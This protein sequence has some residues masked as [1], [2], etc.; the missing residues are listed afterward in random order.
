M[1]L[2]PQPAHLAASLLLALTLSSAANAEAN[3]CGINGDCAD[4]TI[5]NISSA[6]VTAVKIEQHTTDGACKYADN[7]YSQNLSGWSEESFEVAL[8][9]NCK[10]KIKFK[11]TSGC[12]GDKTTH[13]TPENFAAGKE[14]VQLEGACGSLK[15]YKL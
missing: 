15:T 7:N 11:T 2:K 1:P 9:V 10:Y 5:K 13:L 12:S 8:N 4:I 3:F 14:K 6:L